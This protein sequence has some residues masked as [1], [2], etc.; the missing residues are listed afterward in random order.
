MMEQ[1]DRNPLTQY[2]RDENYDY[3]KNDI[4]SVEQQ[5][6]IFDVYPEA[7]QEFD[8]PTAVADSQSDLL[9]EALGKETRVNTS[10]ELESY[11]N[12]FDKLDE[13]K[14]MNFIDAASLDMAEN[15]VSPQDVLAWRQKILKSAKASRGS[16]VY[17]SLVDDR[18]NMLAR[19]NQVAA[20]N[21]ALGNEDVMQTLAAV[22]NYV[23]NRGMI[24]DM[25]QK[26][27]SRFMEQGVMTRMAKG[28]AGVVALD[29]FR[30]ASMMSA[31]LREKLGIETKS[32][33]RNTFF[34]KARLALKDSAAKLTPNQMKELVNEIDAELVNGPFTYGERADF[35]KQ[36]V[37]QD[38]ALNAAINVADVVGIGLGG[39]GVKA[40][41]KA[42]LKA[43][44]SKTAVARAS[45]YGAMNEI[46]PGSGVIGMAAESAVKSP[47]K[48]LLLLGQKKQAALVENALK[49]KVAPA[50]LE[51]SI[52]RGKALADAGQQIIESGLSAVANNTKKLPTST[53]GKTLSRNMD[54][55]V[56]A[57]AKSGLDAATM[58]TSVKLAD[59]LVGSNLVTQIRNAAKFDIS[60]NFVENLN[61]ALDKTNMPLE[62]LATKTTN[63]VLETS[64]LVGSGT[65]KTKGFRTWAEAQHI[66]KKLQV[67]DNYMGFTSK[68]KS[69]V[70][71][72]DGGY[73]ISVSRRYD[74]GLGGDMSLGDIVKKRL[75]EGSPKGARTEYSSSEVLGTISSTNTVPYYVRKLNNA[76]QLD[77]AK[78]MEDLRSF[79]TAVEKGNGP[80]LDTL[81]EYTRANEAWIKEEALKQMGVPDKTIDA[82]RAIKV[83][84]DTDYLLRGREIL[85]RLE[86]TGMKNIHVNGVRIGLGRPLVSSGDRKFWNFASTKSKTVT[87]TGEMSEQQ[88]LL[89]STSL[90]TSSLDAMSAAENKIT[91]KETQKGI[92]KQRYDE[93][94]KFRTAAERS[95]ED[96][97]NVIR[98]PVLNKIA[99]VDEDKTFLTVAKANRSTLASEDVVFIKMQEAIEDSNYIV[100]NKNMLEMRDPSFSNVLM[101][102]K[103]GRTSFSSNSGF[104]KQVHKGVNEA[105]EDYVKGIATIYAHYDH[106]SVRR[107]A[108]VLENMRQVAIKYKD[109]AGGMSMTQAQ[110]E[111]EKIAGRE[112]TRY[113]NF[114]DFWK[115]CDGDDAIISLDK[116]AK[117]QYAHD[118]MKLQLPNGFDVDDY[119]FPGAS[120][121]QF[122]NSEKAMKKLMRSDAEVF[123]PFAIGD[124][125]RLSIE[126]EVSNEI[127]KITKYSTVNDYTDLMAEDFY[128][129]FKNVDESLKRMS[130]KDA[131]LHYDISRV[132]DPKIKGMMHNARNNYERMLSKPTAWDRK[133]EEVSKGIANWFRPGWNK[134]LD[135]SFRA[136][137]YKRFDSMSPV[138]KLR[139]FAFHWTLGMFNPRQFM[140]QY[141]ASMN[142]ALLSP[143]AA[144]K[145]MPI[146]PILSAYAVS[147]DKSLLART[148]KSLGVS[149]KWMEDI[150]EG[151]KRLD[152]YSKGSFGGAV[153]PAFRGNKWDKIG[154]TIFFD[155]GEHANRMATAYIAAEE[156]LEKGIKL[157]DASPEVVAEWLTRQQNLYL[158]MGRA[159]STELQRGIGGVI[160]Q[161]RGY[162]MRAID[163]MFDT[164]MTAG[165]KTRF[166][167]GNLALGGTK[168]LMGTNL[169]S[170]IYNVSRDYGFNAD[171]ADL[172]YNGLI[173]D[174]IQEHGGTYSVGEFFSTNAGGL[175]EL[176]T[177]PLNPENLP[178]ISAATKGIGAVAGIFEGL[179][180][181]GRQEVDGSVFSHTLDII[182]T[183]AL[184]KK[185]PP[186]L[187]NAATAAWIWN[188][189]KRLNSKG[190]LLDKD[191]DKMDAVLA[192]LGFHRIDDDFAQAIY[193]ANKR[194]KGD[195]AKL[196]EEGIRWQGLMV[197]SSERDR[198]MYTQLFHAYIS[199]LQEESPEVAREVLKGIMS[200][201]NVANYTTEQISRL[202]YGYTMATGRDTFIPQLKQELEQ[203]RKRKE[204]K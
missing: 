88:K 16:G 46:V 202:I 153:D 117:L 78:A 164:T 37:D 35:W 102:Y 57:A 31:Y 201:K 62:S 130:P 110:Q 68:T 134:A 136:K 178:A 77:G 158:N 82:Y 47:I 87:L 133:V 111:F 38:Y 34:E 92:I 160:T 174:Y 149:K 49:E 17:S 129:T 175:L 10:K 189:G 55:L 196:T 192:G 91:R 12:Y 197:N 162:Q 21:M 114:A 116:D 36:M 73:F 168:G 24:E 75:M 29:T 100:V 127:G 98:M 74:D 61:K 109:A 4:Y 6:N 146:H 23:A 167:L 58:R 188:T 50:M 119:N 33:T 137:W 108:P 69:E 30:D 76:T 198:K 184:E 70:V 200:T 101:S 99:S 118:G 43:G 42:M 165:E 56:D 15:G 19:E 64:A 152:I 13:E 79:Q 180:L 112:H 113:A 187:N 84:E 81:M 9:T 25:Y 155:L 107:I 125:P 140:A 176:A 8:L 104:I 48:K 142:A 131:L 161:F 5:N 159:G 193:N 103:P 53:T 65:S 185:L 138:R 7:K 182:N 86:E 80:V 2:V 172:M 44:A 148:A 171:V 115:A 141:M 71:K 105:G 95:E 183:L 18:L 85:K 122:T 97:K 22:Q 20:D 124:A 32:F 59:E 51:N 96:I 41:G 120:M 83:I 11:M 93:G 143:K 191:L 67:E 89:S 194:F 126:E 181:F 54:A 123:N 190:A 14:S 60:R 154:S 195:V 144:A 63:G 121:M 204:N 94:Y 170:T 132:S 145:V 173:D 166:M 72:R 52:E 45:I 26:A 147:G 128:S 3:S 157:K 203:A 66:A 27:E 40:A 106:E 28:L 186:G 90:S 135:D 169:G 163:L 156:A 150:V 151:A 199:G 139:S 177:D 39:L 1:K 179:T